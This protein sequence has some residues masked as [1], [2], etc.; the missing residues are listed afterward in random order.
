MIRLRRDSR[1]GVLPRPPPGLASMLPAATRV[2]RAG[3][4]A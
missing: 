3:P 2:P 1:E 4:H